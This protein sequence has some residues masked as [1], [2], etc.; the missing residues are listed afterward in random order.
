MSD[1]MALRLEAGL[2]HT[3]GVP[4]VEIRLLVDDAQGSSFVDWCV[5]D[6]HMLRE[7]L[8]ADLLRRQ[9]DTSAPSAE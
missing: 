3:D 6:R 2:T 1:L 7:V 4:A 9:S 8:G 5:L